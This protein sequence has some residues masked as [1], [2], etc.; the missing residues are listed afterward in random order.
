MKKIINKLKNMH[1]ITALRD[2]SCKTESKKH[3]KIE[4]KKSLIE[5]EDS[6]PK[7][8]ELLYSQSFFEWTINISNDE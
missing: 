6:I 4:I 8:Y 7:L 5:G 2:V 1:F 3:L